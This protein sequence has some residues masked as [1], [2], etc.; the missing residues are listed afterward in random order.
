MNEEQWD[1]L[2]G[3]F[4]GRE[5][6]DG[7][8]KGAADNVLIA[9][10]PMMSLILETF[11]SI[12]GRKALDFGCGSGEFCTRLHALGF[13]VTGFDTSAGMIASARRRLPEE[14]ELESELAAVVARGEEFDLITAIMVFPFI[15]DLEE[16]FRYLD[17]VLK[18]GGVFTFAVFNPGFIATLL[19]AGKIFKDFDSAVSPRVGVMELVEG[20]RIPVFLREAD[21]YR[22]L[23][24]P[25][26][27]GELMRASPPFTEDFLARFPMDI[28]TREPEFLVM[29]FRKK[30]SN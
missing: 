22:G 21:E 14:I 19:E 6:V 8:P 15:E 16:I 26:G 27:Y 11:A 12:E 4:E 2:S 29:G 17:R 25:M 5:E 1:R 20:V 9:W 7:V 30:A 10:P 28:P 24:E 13:T 18:P 3:L 23:L